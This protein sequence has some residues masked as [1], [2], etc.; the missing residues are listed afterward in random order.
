MAAQSND[1]NWN[2]S[3]RPRS[4]PACS[5]SSKRLLAGKF[6]NDLLPISIKKLLAVQGFALLYRSTVHLKWLR[7]IAKHGI[8]PTKIVQ[9]ADGRGLVGQLREV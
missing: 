1:R 3:C 4:W 2:V 8:R 7:E 6:K 9:G 5:A